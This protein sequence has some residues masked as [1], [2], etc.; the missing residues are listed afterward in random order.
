MVCDRCNNGTLSSL[1]Q[2]I[3]EFFPVKMRRTML[4]IRSKAGVVPTTRVSTGTVENVGLA[5]LRFNSNTEAPMLRE[6]ERQG[7][8]VRLQMNLSGGRRRT[9]RYGSELSRILLKS[10][11]ECARLDHGE[12]M[13]EPRF[14]HVRSAVLGSRGMG[15]W[16]WPGRAIRIA[17]MSR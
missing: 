3:C 17:P 13:L 1:D 8:T 14:D 9:P 15:S 6:M 11:L 5:S 7:G 2:A 16:P 10:A 12:L 4:G